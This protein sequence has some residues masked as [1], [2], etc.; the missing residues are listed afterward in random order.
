[1][2][3][4]DHKSHFT[5]HLVFLLAV[6]DF[7]NNHDPDVQCDCTSVSAVMVLFMHRSLLWLKHLALEENMRVNHSSCEASYTTA[8][9]CTTSSVW[10][11]Q[12]PA[13]ERESIRNPPDDINENAKHNDRGRLYFGHSQW[14]T[15]VFTLW[16]VRSSWGAAV[17]QSSIREPLNLL[18]AEMTSL[19]QPFSFL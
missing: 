10:T 2:T 6:A 1:M 19:H 12:K 3:N 4:F 13:R 15:V 8:L 16:V 5:T 17:S 11:P 7:I 18:R 9:T 14:V